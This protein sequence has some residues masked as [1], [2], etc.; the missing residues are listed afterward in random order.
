MSTVPIVEQVVVHHA[1]VQV[2]QHGEGYELH[3]DVPQ[4][5]TAKRYTIRFDRSGWQ[6]FRTLIEAAGSGI[7]IARLVPEDNGR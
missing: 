1:G 5:Q 6:H 2:E 7:E 4:G 3:L